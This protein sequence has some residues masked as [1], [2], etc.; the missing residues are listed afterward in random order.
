MPRSP[1][2]QSWYCAAVPVHLSPDALRGLNSAFDLDEDLGR[3]LE[4]LLHDLDENPLPP[5][6]NVER[7]RTRPLFRL[8][9]TSRGQQWSLLWT[10][11]EDGSAFVVDVSPD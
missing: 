11:R 10:M 3:S 8:A 4:E 5:H 7:F 9:V 1:S 6:L 2:A